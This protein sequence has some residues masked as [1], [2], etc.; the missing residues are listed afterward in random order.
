M[1][2]EIKTYTQTVI[3]DSGI[4][5][6]VTF[7]YYWEEQIEECHGVHDLSGWSV[8][9][10]YVELVV[11]G[12]TVKFNGECNILKYL[13]NSQYLKI[14]EQIDINEIESK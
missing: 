13:D 8:G 6:L 14:L 4:E 7:D 10:T 1:A 11:A 3:S 5:L 9:L 2:N 12:K